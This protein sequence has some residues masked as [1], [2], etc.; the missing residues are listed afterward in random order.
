MT[1]DVKHWKKSSTDLSKSV[2][3]LEKGRDELKESMDQMQGKLSKQILTLQMEIKE[4]KSNASPSY[5]FSVG[6]PTK[7]M[8]AN[9]LVESS[10][11][12]DDDTEKMQVSE[13]KG[14]LRRGTLVTSNVTNKQDIQDSFV[15]AKITHGKLQ[16]SPTDSSDE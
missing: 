9:R 13:S 5:S 14:P 8:L 12:S 2:C 1:F 3:D 15:P 10:G 6:P 11:H 16:R 4:L 7:E